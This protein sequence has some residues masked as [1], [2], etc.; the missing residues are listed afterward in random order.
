MKGQSFVPMR[1]IC[2]G[3][4]S[5]KN[6]FLIVYTL[7]LFCSGQFPPPLG[8]GTTNTVTPQ[9]HTTFRLVVVVVVVA[10]D[11]HVEPFACVHSVILDAQP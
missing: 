2:D 9:L 3:P 11:T 1:V 7:T 6:I 8:R 10:P 4:T 5:L